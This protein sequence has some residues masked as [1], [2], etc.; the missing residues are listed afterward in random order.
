MLREDGFT[1]KFR[2][3]CLHDPMLL[4][5]TAYPTTVEELQT[6]LNTT[7]SWN[8]CQGGPLI[9]ASPKMDTS[10]FRK[11]FKDEGRFG[12]MDC[13]MFVKQGSICRK[14]LN[15]DKMFVY[16]IESQNKKKRESAVAAKITAYAQLQSKIRKLR[17]AS[18]QINTTP[19]SRIK[20]ARLRNLLRSKTSKLARKEKL[21]SKL[22]ETIKDV[23]ESNV[24]TT[25][26]ILKR[27]GVPDM[28]VSFIINVANNCVLN[29]KFFP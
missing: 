7:A 10:K 29:N 25:T 28:Q 23:S 13:E 27:N 18:L 11:V 15:L 2:D 9:E 6:I 16:N 12:H 17:R 8:V 20:L 21:V 24:E 4:N 14:C 26:N 19:Q 3:K 5:A 22:E 1:L